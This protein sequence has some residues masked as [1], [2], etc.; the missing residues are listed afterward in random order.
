MNA[1][2]TVKVAV[3]HILSDVV[4]GGVV[5]PRTRTVT[6]ASGQFQLKRP[7]EG[8]HSV[9]LECPVCTASILAEVSDHTR[10]RRV[11][12]IWAVV[13]A[14]SLVVFVAALGYAFQ[15]GG[16]TLPEGQSLPVLFPV[17][18]VAVFVGFAMAPTA[19]LRSRNH[20][21]V[22]MLD[23]P[24]PRRGHRIVPVRD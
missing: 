4:K 13:S 18:V 24:R 11:R 9:E 20:V 2:R 10:T 17:S 23:A 12:N 15:E 7:A 22:T 19:W 3:R 5:T 8:R 1:Q 16:K 6:W 14:I 21:G